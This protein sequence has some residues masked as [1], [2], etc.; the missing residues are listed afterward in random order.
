MKTNQNH[1]EDL[2]G[3]NWDREI[4]DLLVTDQHSDQHSSDQEKRPPTDEDVFE[5]ETDFA[6][7]DDEPEIAVTH[8]EDEIQ[9]S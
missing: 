8:G 9:E 6:E 1:I 4:I 2:S 3:N 5:L 7:P